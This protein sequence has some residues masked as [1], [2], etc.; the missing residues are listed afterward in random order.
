MGLSQAAQERGDS[1]EGELVGA[2]IAAES[3]AT[4]LA[5]VKAVVAGLRSQLDAAST[6]TDAVEELTAALEKK[7]TQLVQVGG[8]CLSIDICYLGYCSRD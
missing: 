4:E 3:A 1:L 8:W 7:E 2:Q 5:S 6:N